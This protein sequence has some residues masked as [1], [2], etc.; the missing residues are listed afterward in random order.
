[1]TEV[2]LRT[3]FG[4]AI[5]LHYLFPVATLGLSW[6]ILLFQSIAIFKKDDHYH[7]ISNFLIKIFTPLFVIGVASG[8]MMPFLIGMSWSSFSIF[9][10]DVFGS[11]LSIEALVAFSLE[12]IFLAILIFGKER[13]SPRM[14]LFSTFCV[15]FGA[16]LSAFFIVAANSWLQTPAGYAIQDGKV[17]VTNLFQAL[18]NPSA[19]VRF[20]H[21]IVAAWIAGSLISCALAASFVLKGKFLEPAKKMLRLSVILF[22]CTAI[23]ELFVGHEHI[24][25]VLHH[26]PIKS[27]GY[28]GIFYT[29]EGAPLY[30][31]GVPDAKQKKINYGIKIPYLLS[32]L[33]GFNPK[34]KV[35][36]L[37]DFPESEWPP[38]NVI[39]TTFHAMVGLGFIFIGM[40]VVGLLLIFL[41]KL[42]TTKIY[43]R[44][45]TFI[46][47]LPFI[48]SE[49]GW[50]G[51]EMG[52]Q[53]WLIYGVMKTS[54]GI[55]PHATSNEVLIMLTILVC[56]YA[57]F[58]TG[59]CF[60]LPGI[61]KKGLQTNG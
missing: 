60:I 2:L 3:Q 44:I 31:G 23:F 27:P 47:P 46:F 21:V 45:L 33:E 35:I 41:K 32:I 50:I 4:I 18:L 59:L 1:M 19:I 6:M 5:G 54:E 14:Y 51:T 17:I 30:L 24:M 29:Q 8:L 11:F 38:V 57:L 20:I 16:H 61:I 28:E 48:A 58:V 25:S 43:L 34:T 52:R 26:Q 39:F 42:Y 9:S 36:G 15:F 7:A 56:I 37:T 12:S 53:P 55:T 49:L 13:V 22:A 10:G 40:G